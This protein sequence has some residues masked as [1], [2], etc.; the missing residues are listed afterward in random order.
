[1]TGSGTQTDP[2]IVDSWAEFESVVPLLGD[3]T[4]DNHVCVQFNPNATNKVIDM[5]EIYPDGCPNYYLDSGYVIGNGWEIR[6]LFLN[7]ILF[8]IDTNGIIR[9]FKFTNFVHQ[10]SLPFISTNNSYGSNSA[11]IEEN[12][13]S[14]YTESNIFL[15]QGSYSH[16]SPLTIYNN[17]FDLT[18]SNSAFCLAYG[19]DTSNDFCFNNIKIH[20]KDSS[21]INTNVGLFYGSSGNNVRDNIFDITADTGC[22][23]TIT[24]SSINYFTRNFVTGLNSGKFTQKNCTKASRVINVYNKDTTT[25]SRSYN[26]FKACTSE[27]LSNAEYLT[28]LKFATRTHKTIDST[29]VH[30]FNNSNFES[31][32][33]SSS[34][35]TTDANTVR[36]VGYIEVDEFPVCVDRIT[37]S[38]TDI[39]NKPITV[40]FRLYSSNT[41]SSP[42]ITLSNKLNGSVIVNTN[43]FNLTKQYYRI[44]L[45]YSDGSALTPD[46]LKSC[47]ITFKIGYWYID[48][49]N[50]LTNIAFIK[51]DSFI[52]PI[53]NPFPVFIGNKRIKEIFYGSKPIK[54][55]Y[56]GKQKIY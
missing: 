14:G 54:F 56:Y 36:T 7:H 47:T 29:I 21:A 48:D 37:V 23:F 11:Y 8:N 20:L 28:S 6:N 9:G 38:A 50:Q 46:K 53:E 41:S 15:Q 24:P 18:V 4:Y 26:N 13:F 19:I 1:M 5:Q 27:Q 40:D 51:N 17:T 35:N 30:T 16:T 39:E 42:L 52:P 2:Y 43:S 32:N 33:I 31:G 55:I 45:K 22:N 10:T 12:Y 25:I 34:G 49:D 44:V 3:S